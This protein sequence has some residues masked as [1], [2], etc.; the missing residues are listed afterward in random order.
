MF[1]SCSHIA[2]SVTAHILI[3][4]TQLLSGDEAPHQHDGID[5]KVRIELELIELMRGDKPLRLQHVVVELP[6]HLTKGHHRRLIVGELK[7][8]SSN[9]GVSVNEAP[10]RS[11]TLGQHMIRE[12]GIGAGEVEQEFNIDD[13]AGLY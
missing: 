13:T 4:H 2:D 3:D 6:L 10:W 9:T 8:P 7:E 11:A 12:V 1:C 5:G